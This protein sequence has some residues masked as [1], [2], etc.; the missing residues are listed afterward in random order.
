MVC[1]AVLLLLAGTRG[2]TAPNASLDTVPVAYFGGVNT[3]RGADNIEML[4][5]MRVV[6]IEK[7]EGTCWSDCLAQGPGGAAC[8]PSCAV[9][10]AMLGTLR[11]VKAANPGV[12]G[13][14]YLNT[15]LAFPFY[16]LDAAFMHAHSLTID[17]STGQP[18][19][20]RNDN[21]MEGINVFGFDTDA[22]AALYAAAARNLTATGI[23][24]GFFGDKWA[25]GA[26]PP[27]HKA[28]A[29]TPWQ[30]CNH[31]CGNVSAAQGAAWN[32][33]KARALRAVNDATAPG[34]WVTNGDAFD[35]GD[36]KP[37]VRGNTLHLHAPDG[38]S[39]TKGDPRLLA[40]AVRAG[41]ENHSYVYLGGD[42]H[43]ET[44]PNDPASLGAQCGA[45]DCVAR[46]LLAVE[47]GAFLGAQGW[48]PDFAKPLGEPL[49]PA[50]YTPAARGAHA[51]L[52]RNFSSGTYVRFEYN[53]KGD[54]G[55][56]QVWWEG[57]APPPPPPPPTLQCGG[58][59]GARGGCGSTLLNDTSFSHHDVDKAHVGVGSASACCGLCAANAACA[60]WAWHTTQNNSCHLHSADPDVEQKHQKG[61]VA[62]VMLRNATT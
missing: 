51:L 40:A 13:V 33:G 57:R 24:D 25:K 60:K 39:L 45:V 22:G 23:V 41:L 19:S 55:V 4:A 7:W 10:D 58:S 59:A 30:I 46:F 47:R 15:L 14:F 6:M 17:V 9:E 36:G 38:G 8:Q 49:A 16:A 35:G 2:I 53:D 42:Q 43:W 18:I 3:T 1:G 61:T 12:C 29:T 52:E 37:P 27:G 56:G 62:G 11:R 28:P 20:I 31:E 54:D 34:I 5:K 21:G 44:D 50:R 26:K 32:A 48:D